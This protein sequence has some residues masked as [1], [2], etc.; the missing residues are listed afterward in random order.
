[1][2]LGSL[3]LTTISTSSSTERGSASSSVRATTLELLPEPELLPA[4]LELPLLLQKH[5][6]RPGRPNQSTTIEINQ[7]TDQSHRTHQMDRQGMHQIMGR[8][9]PPAATAAAPRP[10]ASAAA[11]PS[12]RTPSRI[13][14]LLLLLLVVCCPGALAFHPSGLA[15]RGPAARGSG[16]AGARSRQDGL[17]VLSSQPQGQEEGVSRRESLALGGALAGEE[18][19]GGRG[20]T[21]TEAGSKQ[22]SPIG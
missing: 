21:H 17:V 20:E 15:A 12:C 2:E 14:L 3:A 5:G 16:G 19:R 9:P 22:Q 1:M 6:G 13:L 18:D 10:A 7:P 11:G 4:W 8:P